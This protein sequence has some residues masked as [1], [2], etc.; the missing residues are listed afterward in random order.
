MAYLTQPSVGV[1]GGAMSSFVVAIEDNLG[2]IVVGN[3]SAVTLTLTH[4]IFSNGQ[5]SVT[6]NAVDGIATFSD[7]A[8]STPDSYLRFSGPPTPA[9]TSTPAPGRSRSP[10][11][12]R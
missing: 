8:M 5:S 9:S 1:A 6:A 11:C 7:L 10:C 12:P 2:N 4:G 3:T